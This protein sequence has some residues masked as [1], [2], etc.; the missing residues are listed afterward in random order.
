M[1][2]YKRL[3]AASLQR[4]AGCGGRAWAVVRRD[5]VALALLEGIVAAMGDS[6][7]RADARVRGLAVAVCCCPIGTRTVQG[8]MKQRDQ[9]GCAGL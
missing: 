9:A 7:V 1:G 2:A 4:L 3:A 5:T 6:I 8:E